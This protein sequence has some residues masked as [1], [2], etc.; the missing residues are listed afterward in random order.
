M[1]KH[2]KDKKDVG[3]FSSLAGLMQQCRYKV[4]IQSYL[5]VSSFLHLIFHLVIHVTSSLKL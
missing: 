1:I 2:L 3:F 4:V 5:Q